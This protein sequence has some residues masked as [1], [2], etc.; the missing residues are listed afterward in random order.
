MWEVDFFLLMLMFCGLWWLLVEG[1]SGFLWLL[2]VFKK[3]EGDICDNFYIEYMEIVKGVILELM[4][5]CIYLREG[6]LY[7]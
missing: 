3:K 5:I 7:K 6:L 2:V 1:I 4:Y